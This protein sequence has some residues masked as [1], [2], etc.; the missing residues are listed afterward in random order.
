[1]TI[2]LTAS[3]DYLLSGGK[4]DPGSPSSDEL[5]ARARVAVLGCTNSQSRLH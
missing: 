4:Q 1:M 5:E 3:F 2:K